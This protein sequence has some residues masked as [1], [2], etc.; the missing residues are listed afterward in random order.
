ML[1]LVHRYKEGY[2]TQMFGVVLATTDDEKT[3]N[4]TLNDTKAENKQLLYFA[5]DGGRAE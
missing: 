1:V 2:Q 4:M 5:G 3:T